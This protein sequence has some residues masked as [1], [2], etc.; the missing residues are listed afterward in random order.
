M[1]EILFT[2]DDSFIPLPTV[3][4]PKHA[5]SQVKPPQTCER[6]FS[7]YEI[8][9]SLDMGCNGTVIGTC[10]VHVCLTTLSWIL[11][12]SVDWVEFVLYSGG[13]WKE[14]FQFDSTL[15]L[16]MTLPSTAAFLWAFQF[17]NMR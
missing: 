3:V 7:G 8:D 2:L 1:G 5:R 17:P 12:I 11:A 6:A 13:L 16:T 9:H 10:A 14:C 4:H 15:L